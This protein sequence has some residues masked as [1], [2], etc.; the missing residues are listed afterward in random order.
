M[1]HPP[2]AR[3]T[4]TDTARTMAVQRFAAEPV[5]P[6]G[7]VAAVGGT[8]P[9]GDV[10]PPGDAPA[11]GPPHDAAAADL[12]LAGAPRPDPVVGEPPSPEP[13]GPDG[14]APSTAIAPTLSASPPRLGLGEPLQDPSPQHPVQRATGPGSAD[15]P[16]RL[17]RTVTAEP[18]NPTTPAPPRPPRGGLGAPLVSL[19]TP[20]E[21]TQQEA[22]RGDVSPPQSSPP[23]RTAPLLGDWGHSDSGPG[24]AVLGDSLLGDPGLGGSDPGETVAGTAGDTPAGISATPLPLAIQRSTR[25]AGDADAAPVGTS[26]AVPLA[27]AGQLGT[28][29]V[30][31]A[32]GMDTPPLTLVHDASIPRATTV[33]PLLGSAAWSDG[34]AAGSVQRSTNPAVATA[35]PAALHQPAAPSGGMPTAVAPPVTAPSQFAVFPV[36]TFPAGSG[37]SPSAAAVMPL[38]GTTSAG[39]AVQRAAV[40]RASDGD[41]PRMPDARP[42]PGVHQRVES[43]SA[44]ASM[45]MPLPGPSTAA[46]PAQFNGW[47]GS[48]RD[49]VAEPLAVQRVPQTVAE[50]QHEGLETLLQR[51][52]DVGEITSGGSAPGGTETRVGPPAEPPAEQGEEGGTGGGGGLGHPREWDAE[53]LEVAS[54]RLYDRISRRIKQELRTDRE[55]A[56]HLMDVRR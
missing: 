43:A 24:D 7:D 40:Q 44:A 38:G 50:H 41:W 36:D 26:R 14:S 8:S 55:R 30:V 2:S 53:V 17:Q 31:R 9:V 49:A 10:F 52:V 6:A 51:R 23:E 15:A 11:G 5:P 22:P 27:G 21:A 3:P 34:A 48:G 56:G 45:A 13:A 46:R 37:S 47:R 32:H 25:L 18:T 39:P 28:H 42:R 35:Q 33:A 12:P 1:A 4:G 20:Q 19:P 16:L 54:R 29:T